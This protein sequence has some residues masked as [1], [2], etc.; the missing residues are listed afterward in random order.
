MWRG[1]RTAKL[2]LA[3]WRKAFFCN[4]KMWAVH[5]LRRNMR[6]RCKARALLPS[7]AVAMELNDCEVGVYHA[8]ESRLD[9]DLRG[10]DWEDGQGAEEEVGDEW[11]QENANGSKN[12]QHVVSSFTYNSNKRGPSGRKV[13]VA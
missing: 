9:E 10:A 2:A 12:T 5:G 8:E 4:Y 1:V 3:Q 11:Q 6:V 13:A 7:G